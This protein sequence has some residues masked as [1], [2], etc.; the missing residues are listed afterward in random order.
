MLETRVTYMATVSKSKLHGM[1][2]LNVLV[3][4]VEEQCQDLHHRLCTRKDPP[5]LGET[6]IMASQ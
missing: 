2:D 4:W 6:G 1:V 3:N 5:K